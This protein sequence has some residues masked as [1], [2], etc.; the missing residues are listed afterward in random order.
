MVDD[1]THR[2][3]HAEILTIAASDPFA[4]Q[5]QVVNAAVEMLNV[6]VQPG[7]REALQT[8]GTEVASAYDFYLQGLGYLQNYDK[9]EN[10]ESAVKVFDTALQ[11]D[12]QYALAYAGRGQ[13]YCEMYETSENN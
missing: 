13:A 11:L 7:E 5:D 10:I 2:Q 12:P 3:V 1:R 6:E 9:M 8:H 4:V